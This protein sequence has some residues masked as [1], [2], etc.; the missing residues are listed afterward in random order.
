MTEKFKEYTP[1]ISPGAFVAPGAHII[2]QVS[3]A[4]EVSIW[5]NAVLRGDI[6][7]ITVGRGSNVQDNCTLHCDH[8]MELL[9][10]ENVTVGHNA[11]LHSCTVGDGS[12]I[13]MGAIVL[14]GAKIGKGCLVAAGALVTQNAEIPDG[15]LV[16][17]S[18]AKVKRILSPEKKQK[19]LDNAD[20]Y[21]RLIK[22]Y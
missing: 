3:I 7:K 9:I 15:S 19:L 13:G 21:V 1:E 16:I 4:T 12:L 11:V 17:G 14:D 18:P 20:E 2:G 8:G 6:E 10:G 22:E 5:H